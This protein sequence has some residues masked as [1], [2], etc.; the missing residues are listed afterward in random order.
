MLAPDPA[1]V[2][3][4]KEQLETEKRPPAGQ[5][6]QPTGQTNPATLFGATATAAAAT[7]ATTNVHETE[8]GV[9]LSW[10]TGT[11]TGTGTASGSG[12][13]SGLGSR[14]GSSN[15]I[16]IEAKRIIFCFAQGLSCVIVASRARTRYDVR[17]FL[18][19]IFAVF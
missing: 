18:R 6:S 9:R 10:R 7:T 17:G 14:C 19:S 16:V 13:G 12:S 1:S 2:R 8:T 5:T 15:S 4:C 3:L 11:G